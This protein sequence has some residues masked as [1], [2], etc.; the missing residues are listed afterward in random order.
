LFS[1]AIAPCNEPFLFENRVV[2]GAIPKEFVPACEQGFR[3]A[4]A[5]GF[6]AGYPIVGV[7]VIL[8]G[9][10]FH[11]YDSSEMAFRL[12]AQQAFEQAF[13][14]AKP[15]LLEPIMRLE[16]ETPSEFVGRVQGDLS[17]RR[18]LILSSSTGQSDSTIEAEVPLAKMFGYSTE[19]RSLTSGMAT[20]SMEFACYRQAI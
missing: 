7:K 5:T 8:D 12:A 13:N 1:R 14:L 16:V 2:G 20:F 9:G 4:I 17:A 19:L 11:A 6:L 15:Y 10:S 3:D 18:G